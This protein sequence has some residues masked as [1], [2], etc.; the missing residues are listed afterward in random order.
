MSTDNILLPIEIVN[1]ILIQR[2]P[3]PLV[4]IIKERFDSYYTGKL[5]IY[6]LD[7]MKQKMERKRKVMYDYE[8]K[9][10][11]KEVNHQI[12]RT[13]QVT[14]CGDECKRIL[15]EHLINC[16]K[17]SETFLSYDC[18]FKSD[19]GT[20]SHYWEIERLDEILDWYSEQK[21]NREEKYIDIKCKYQEQLAKKENR[22]EEYYIEKEDEW[23]DF[24]YFENMRISSEQRRGIHPWA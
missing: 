9:I 11:E 15:N 13:E 5:T 8:L 3:H 1:K 22:L 2:E 7:I 19:N 16:E 21:D 18:Q 10:F 14:Q 6:E 23:D 12:K 4:E 20:C 17:C 24:C